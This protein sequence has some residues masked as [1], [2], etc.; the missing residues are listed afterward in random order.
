MKNTATGSQSQT[1][2]IG[3]LEIVKIVREF[4]ALETTADLNALTIGQM[5]DEH[6]AS[7]A[8]RGDE[9]QTVKLDLD[10][11]QWREIAKAQQEINSRYGDFVA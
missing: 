5:I 1:R 11:D 3:G 8:N 9:V 7:A 10:S 6:L 2:T 4:V